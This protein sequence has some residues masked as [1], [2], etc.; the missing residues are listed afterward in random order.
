MAT[1]SALLL[2]GHDG[3]GRLGRGSEDVHSALPMEP[4]WP[5]A[6]GIEAYACGAAHSVAVDTAGGV[7][8]WGKC[9]FGQL[10]HGELDTDEHVPRLVKGLA[11]VRVLLVGAGTSHVIVGAA[12]ATFAFGCGFFGALGH[13]SEQ[14]CTEPRRVEALDGLT[15]RA[16]AGGDFHSL[17]VADDGALFVFGS[18]KE[19]QLG[20]DVGPTAKVPVRVPGMRASAVAAGARHSVVVRADDG[21]LLAC[22]GSGGTL[23]AEVGLTG[24]AR[25]AA[26]TA[27]WMAATAGNELYAFGANEHGQLGLP[28]TEVKAAAKPTRV[29]LPAAGMAGRGAITGLACGHVHTVV[30]TDATDV[31]TFGERT[32]GKLGHDEAG[33]ASPLALPAPRAVVG[34]AA[35]SNHTALLLAKP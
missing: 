12:G 21:A 16:A 10:G 33:I 14:S 26:G 28:L 34:C 30:V 7:W 32:F 4:V 9:H 24:V 18:N 19:G 2:F 20:L 31:F 5:P 8:T 15:L 6:V 3:Y 23:L 1:S 22:G 29:P 35:G 25:V 17:V 27:H 13:G 11:G